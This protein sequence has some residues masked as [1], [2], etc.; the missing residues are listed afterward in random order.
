MNLTS[1]ELDG[2]PPETVDRLLVEP[3]VASSLLGDSDDALVLVDLGSGGGS[4]GIPMAI[5]RPAMRLTLVE[6]RERK[7]AFLREA[8]RQVSLAHAD[9]LTR[10]ANEI[11]PE[12]FGL[13]DVVSARALRLDNEL[14]AVVRRLL[15]AHGR[16]LTF[17]PN[18]QPEGFTVLAERLVGE[19][20]CVRS[21]VPR[22][23]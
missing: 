4:P 13:A 19:A 7:S 18:V 17:G 21:L 11:P 16:L 5:A 14:L 23:P 9:V 6:P 10:R 8:C 20:I 22:R 12:Y 15:N 1:L 3:L 2:Y